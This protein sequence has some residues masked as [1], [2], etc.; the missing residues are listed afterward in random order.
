[1]PFAWF[2]LVL[3][4]IVQDALCHLHGFGYACTYNYAYAYSYAGHV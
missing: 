4:R 1:M 2:W 3:A